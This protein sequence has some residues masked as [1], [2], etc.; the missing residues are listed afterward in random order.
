MN[1]KNNNKKLNYNIN[2]YIIY[3]NNYYNRNKK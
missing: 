3:N 1:T 2:I